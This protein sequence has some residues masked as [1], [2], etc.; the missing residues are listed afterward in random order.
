MDGGRGRRLK[1]RGFWRFKGGRRERLEIQGWRFGGVGDL[2][3]EGLR[4]GREM[5][6]M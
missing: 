6:E 1:G 5:L 4:G 3:V 2:R